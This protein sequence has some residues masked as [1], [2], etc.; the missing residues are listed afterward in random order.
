MSSEVRVIPGEPAV[1][2]GFVNLPPQPAPPPSLLFTHPLSEAVTVYLNHQNNMYIHIQ[3]QSLPPD[4]PTVLPQNP[5]TISFPFFYLSRVSLPCSGV[6]EAAVG[7]EPRK[8]WGRWGMMD[9]VLFF[10]LRACVFFG[11]ALL[12]GTFYL[13]R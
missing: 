3:V 7:P 5:T 11:I 9:D 10:F 1:V 2:F 8:L 13:L 6:S 4:T 12:L